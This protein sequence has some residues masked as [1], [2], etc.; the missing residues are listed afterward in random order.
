MRT[1]PRSTVHRLRCA[2]GFT[3]MELLVVVALLGMLVAILLPSLQRARENAKTVTCLTNLRQLA[4]GWQMYADE[5]DDTMAPGRMARF[6]GG[7]DNPANWYDVG[8]GL[9]YRPRWPATLAAQVGIFAFDK[10]STED[11]RQDYDS[12]VLLCP[13]VREWVDERN[14]AFGYN[15][16][17]LGNARRT[18]D[19]FYNFPVKRSRLR[20]VGNTV[21]F[22]DCMGTA[23]GYPRFGRRP[24]YNDGEPG[25]RDHGPE[26]GNHGWTLDPPRLT[27][28]SDHGTGD[29]GSRRTAVD[30]RHSQRVNVVF[31]DTHGETADEAA[32]GYRKHEDGR[33]VDL[34]APP[35]SELGPPHNRK[36]A[37]TG[38]D[39][40]PPN[41]PQ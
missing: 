34:D 17:F 31:T 10:P 20:D 6:S 38:R 23:A 37:G 5:N 41:R 14:F 40:D 7:T 2:A 24:Y 16:Q 33:Y 35:A 9:K 28:L 29:A 3:L 8:N 1:R 36:F 18:N 13:K 19:R 22:G 4:N 26:L 27:E 39:V 11:D 15:H 25:V 30:P 21:L 32:L 12:K